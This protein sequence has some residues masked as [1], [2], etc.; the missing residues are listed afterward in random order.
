MEAMA[1]VGA[2]LLLSDKRFKGMAPLIGAIAEVK[3]RR[4][5]VP[6]DR[7]ETDITVM[8]VKGTIGKCL[9]VGTVEG[10]SV[11]TFE[12]IFKIKDLDSA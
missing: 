8:W 2:V 6:G 4:P 7:L 11:A 10:E 1:Q 9:A 3:F 5:V 12:M